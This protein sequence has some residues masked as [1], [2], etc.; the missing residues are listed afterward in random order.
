MDVDQ[1]I[2]VPPIAKDTVEKPEVKE[3]I[4]I[5]EN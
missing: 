3:E 1:P 4:K 2:I 5:E